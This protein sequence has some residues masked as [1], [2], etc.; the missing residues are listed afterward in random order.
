MLVHAPFTLVVLTHSPYISRSSDFQPCNFEQ[1]HGAPPQD[2]YCSYAAPGP[3]H[4]PSP[5]PCVSLSGNLDAFWKKVECAVAILSRINWGKPSETHLAFSHS[6]YPCSAFSH[7]AFLHS[8]LYSTVRFLNS[9]LAYF[10]M[11]FQ[12]W[13]FCPCYILTC[14]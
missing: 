6:A 9:L 11:I 8:T 12:M 4:R 13:V 2:S 14:R 10:T 3:L 7:P 1:M 5:P